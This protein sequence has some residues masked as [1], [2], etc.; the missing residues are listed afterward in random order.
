MEVYAG[1]PGPPWQTGYL[2][3]ADGNRLAGD[4]D[5]NWQ[6]ET[7]LLREPDGRIRAFSASQV[8]Q[9]GWQASPSQ[10]AR[11]FVALPGS[12]NQLP[13]SLAF[14]E[15]CAEGP[16]TV[17]RRMKRTHGLFKRAYSNPIRNFDPET[18]DPHDSFFDY[19]AYVDGQFLSFKRFYVDIYLAR[20]AAYQQE[21]RQFVQTRHLNEKS[22]F[23]QLR[24]VEQYNQLVERQTASVKTPISY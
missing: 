2:V 9:F 18:P 17:V 5:Y 13:A 7:V 3:L 6:A 8:Q 4:L 24:I 22:Q 11:L 12:I 1:S 15:V 10:R 19:F 20:M 23:G 16:L 21:L 14:F